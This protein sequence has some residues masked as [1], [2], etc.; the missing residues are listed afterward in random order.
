[1]DNRYKRVAALRTSR[2]MLD[3]M[4]ENEIR[5][6]FDVEV[7][8]APQGSLAQALEIDGFKVGNRLA[9]LP[10]EGWDGTPDGHPSEQTY[11]RWQRFGF[12]GAK[13]VWGGEAVAVRHEGRANPNQLMINRATLSDL[14]GLRSELIRAHAQTSSRTDD[15][16]IGLQLTHSGRFCRPNDKKRMEP[17]LAYDHPLLNPKFGLPLDSGRVVSD[18]WMDDLVADFVKAAVLVH[19]IGFDFVDV[20]HCHGY[21]GHELLSAVQRPGRY[22]GSM[23]N[24]ARFLKEVTLGIQR[25]AP[26]MKIGVRLSAFDFV[27]FQKG[28]N[29]IGVPAAIY[30]KGE[31]PFAFG[32][33]GTGVG[34][35][36]TE[37]IELLQVMQDLGIRMVC[38]TGGSPY[39]DPHI[40]RPA[41]TPPSDGY[42]PPEDPLISVTRQVEVTRQLKERFP[43]MVVVGSAYS[44][45][46]DWLPNVAQAVVRMG[47]ADSVGL[48]RMMLSYPEMAADILA[49][50]PL[51]RK[52]ICRTFSDCTTAPRNGMISG[53]Y[54][55]DEYYKFRPDAVELAKLKKE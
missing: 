6:P 50:R 55:L 54:P 10:M 37:P 29:E 26:G 23:E 21:L 36:L 22:G 33:D 16:M 51:Q 24:R 46:Q 43:R 13:L 38:I 8:A 4:K 19:E 9:V 3:Y 14:A 41:Y 12:S 5:L 27:P 2:Q 45:L 40:Q 49:G 31:Y 30:K 1:M 35:D 25:D 15:L 34:V 17:F 47:W 39:Y 28:P 11:R 32:G 52:L 7:L 53:C 18:L 48:G 20:K 44:C 42:L